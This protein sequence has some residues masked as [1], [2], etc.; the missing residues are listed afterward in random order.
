MM[1]DLYLF[2]KI[3]LFFVDNLGFEFCK[4][5]QH[6]FFVHSMPH[7]GMFEQFFY[8]WSFVRFLDQTK[9][10]EI[11]EFFRPSGWVVEF[12]WVWLLDLQ[13]DPHWRHF[14]EW[15][16]HLC[17]LNHGYPKA[18]NVNLKRGNEN[19]QNNIF[20]FSIF[21]PY[22]HRVHPWMSRR[23]QLQEPSSMGFQWMCPSSDCLPS[24]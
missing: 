2:I 13:Q 23:Q 16:L 22:D 3:H 1:I 14:M 7:K 20:T 10:E 5:I 6:W 24:I 8:I 17:K 15:R 11:I 21:L 4:K 18:P 12:W 9:F 19:W